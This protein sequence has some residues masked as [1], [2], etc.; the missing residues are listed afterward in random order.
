MAH[1]L[2]LLSMLGTLH[3][4]Y[5]ADSLKKHPP[6]HAWALT[7]YPRLYSC[8]HRH[9]LH[10]TCIPAPYS[11]SPPMDMSFLDYFGLNTL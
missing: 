11:V 10:H 1:S 8:V 2:L 9:L 7:S 4:L 3:T 5:K 6:H